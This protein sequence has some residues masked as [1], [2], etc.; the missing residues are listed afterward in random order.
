MSSKNTKYTREY[1]Q[2]IV[3]LYHSGKTYS[4]I[5]KEYG[6]SHSALSNWIKQYSEVKIDDETVLTAKQIKELQKRNAQLEEENLILKKP[7]RYSR[8][9][10]TKTECRKAAVIGTRRH[11]ALPC[12]SCQPKHILQISSS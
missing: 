4:E 5:H 1:K 11:N 2:T 12:A 9:A 8:P 7:L 6:V 10:Q 3:N